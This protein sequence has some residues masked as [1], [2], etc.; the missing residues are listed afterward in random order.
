MRITTK[1]QVTIPLEI[2]ET[3]GLAAQHRGRIRARSDA[4]RMRKAAVPRPR[5]R[6]PLVEHCAGA[7]AGSPRTRS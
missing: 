4:V 1:G 5:P 2:R 3:L 6:T 7:A